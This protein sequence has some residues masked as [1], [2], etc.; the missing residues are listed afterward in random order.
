MISDTRDLLAGPLPDVRVGIGRGSD[1]GCVERSAAAFDDVEIYDDPE[2]LVDDLVSGR[3]D[4]AV[5]GDLTSEAAVP[6]LRRGLGVDRLERAVF[7]E[8]VGGRMFMLAPV[9]IDEGWADEQKVDMAERASDLSRRVGANP[10]IAVMSGGRDDDL[11]RCPQVDRTIGSARA[12]VEALRRDGYDAYGCQILIEDAAREAGVVIA[13]DGM[14][15]NIMFRALH[16][17]GGAQAL[18]APVLNADRVFVDT[19]RAKTDY[20]DSIALAK[21]LTE[22]DR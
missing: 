9:G 15:G 6:A 3:I 20:R 11:G 8:P 2:T 21:R 10:R 14:T 1:R 7:L 5:R 13:P 18:G 17:L 22:A 19:S 12:V 16:F 4:A